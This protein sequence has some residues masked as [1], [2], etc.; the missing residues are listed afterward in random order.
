MSLSV[1]FAE[2]SQSKF[3]LGAEFLSVEASQQLRFET[4][5]FFSHTEERH[6]IDG[7]VI[8]GNPGL[9]FGPVGQSGRVSN[10]EPRGS[11]A[12]VQE[13]G[14]RVSRRLQKITFIKFFRTSFLFLS[15]CLLKI[16]LRQKQTYLH[17]ENFL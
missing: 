17:N 6:G 1:E 16:V 10:P 14:G 3:C 11:T 12:L 13:Q 8:A 5:P 7:R 9:G 2:A 4:F 15:F